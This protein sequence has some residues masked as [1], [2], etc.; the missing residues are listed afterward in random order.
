VT[1]W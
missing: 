1:K